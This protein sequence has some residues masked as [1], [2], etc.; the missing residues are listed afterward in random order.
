MTTGQ[1]PFDLLIGF[2]PHIKENQQQTTNIPGIKHCIAHLK[3]LRDC[4]QMAIRRTQMMTQK[5]AE[6]K[7]GQR[8]F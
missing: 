1:T 8:H 7:K 6:R 5:Y 2:T 4:T 3:T